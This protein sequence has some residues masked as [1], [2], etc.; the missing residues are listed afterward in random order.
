MPIWVA[1]GLMIL[2]FS[3]CIMAGPV[4]ITSLQDPFAK[5]PRTVIKPMQRVIVLQGIIAADDG[6]AAAIACGDDHDVLQKGSS[7]KGYTV[8]MV[9]E[10]SVCLRKDNEEITL[11]LE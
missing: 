6:F 7:F 8:A 2:F 10:T 1:L 4:N 5:P 3:V 9:T 11:V